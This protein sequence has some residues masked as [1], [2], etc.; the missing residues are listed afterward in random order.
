MSFNLLGYIVFAFV[1]SITPGPNNI[2]L[3]SYGRT[4]KIRDAIS[5]MS[6]IM[7]GF[8]VVLYLSGYG[9]TQAI[10]ASPVVEIILKV[11]CS[12]WLVYLGFIL[13]KVSSDIEN[14]ITK[15]LGFREAF[16]MQFINPKAI[17]MAMTGAAVFMPDLGNI[18][19]NVFIFAVI[20]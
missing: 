8:F 11:I 19:L 6:G 1:A 15:K 10:T 7:G 9:I 5:L 13:S 4:N 14:D 20:F 18:H 12:G 17:F 2:M 16:L 3:F